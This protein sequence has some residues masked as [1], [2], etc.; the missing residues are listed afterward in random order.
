MV[1]EFSLKF[2]PVSALVSVMID[3]WMETSTP[4]ILPIETNSPNPIGTSSLMYLQS[5]FAGPLLEHSAN[6]RN[7][8][9]ALMDVSSSLRHFAASKY[10]NGSHPNFSRIS[11]FALSKY[12]ITLTTESVYPS[13][14]IQNSPL[15]NSIL[16]AEKRIPMGCTIMLGLWNADSRIFARE[17]FVSSNSFDKME[18]TLSFFD[19]GN[20]DTALRGL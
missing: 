12:S 17:Y 13:L 6:S 7:D 14:Y 10:P 11:F 2:F 5:I 1:R 8:C 18:S 19:S 9:I 4:R 15:L 3:S 16:D 20:T